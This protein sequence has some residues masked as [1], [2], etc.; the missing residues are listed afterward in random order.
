MDSGFAYLL[1]TTIN[2][3]LVND[4]DNRLQCN[5]NI[6]IAEQKICA[7]DEGMWKCIVCY[8]NDHSR[9]KLKQSIKIEM[10]NKMNEKNFL[11]HGIVFRWWWR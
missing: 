6:T 2:R 9:Y 4:G 1:F 11:M 10:S 8:G 3:V 7:L 5:A